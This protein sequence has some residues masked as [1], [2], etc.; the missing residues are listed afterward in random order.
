[1]LAVLVYILANIELILCK[2]KSK[3]VIDI[4]PTSTVIQ[5]E[6]LNLKY[7]I[8]IINKS[9]VKPEDLKYPPT[10]NKDNYKKFEIPIHIATKL[11]QPIKSMIGSI[12]NMPYTKLPINT[13]YTGLNQSDVLLNSINP[14]NGADKSKYRIMISNDDKDKIEMIID[15]KIYFI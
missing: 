4:P 9:K 8:Y 1:M 13:I 11:N 12:M 3:L 14:L 2:N 7:P 10:F 15:D 5:P 6:Q